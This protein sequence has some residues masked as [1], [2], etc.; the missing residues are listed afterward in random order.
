VQH[1]RISIVEGGE[2]R[3]VSRSNAVDEGCIR[4]RG[5]RTAPP[6]PGEV[7]GNLPFGRGIGERRKDTAAPAL[8]I[9]F[10]VG[11]EL[12]FDLNR[13]FLLTSLTWR[14]M[15]RREPGDCPVLSC[16]RKTSTAS[17]SGEARV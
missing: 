2:R 4:E 12:F 11:I 13:Y 1:A 9:A 5:R 7:A 15:G 17:R 8:T 14:V 6:S 3:F 16:T 10:G